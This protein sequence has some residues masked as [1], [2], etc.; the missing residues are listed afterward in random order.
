LPRGRSGARRH[1]PRRDHVAVEGSIPPHSMTLP[2]TTSP[3]R[4]WKGKARELTRTTRGVSV[5]SL[6]ST[7]RS[8][9]FLRRQP[10]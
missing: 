5:S 3:A 2:I 8:A 10:P 1:L 4:S 7:V 6:R 9:P